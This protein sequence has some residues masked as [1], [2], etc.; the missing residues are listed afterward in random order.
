M[1]VSHCVPITTNNNIHNKLHTH[2][3]AWHGARLS[4]TRRTTYTTLNLNCGHEDLQ[5]WKPK[6][7]ED[8]SQQFEAGDHRTTQLDQRHPGELEHQQ[9]WVIYIFIMVTLNLY[10]FL[11]LSSKSKY[12]YLAARS[13]R[14]EKQIAELLQALSIYARRNA[15]LRDSGD[16]VSEAINSIVTGEVLSLRYCFRL[17][18]S[19]YSHHSLSSTV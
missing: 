9:V 3:P 7:I 6:T 16:N 19:P 12:R 11:R 10:S 15:K 14:F 8:G 18:V 1:I 17:N 13:E 4:F 2:S 5:T